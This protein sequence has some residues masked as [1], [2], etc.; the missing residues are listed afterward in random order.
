MCFVFS[1]CLISLAA[2]NDIIL[3]V[4][5]TGNKTSVQLD[6]AEYTADTGSIRVTNKVKIIT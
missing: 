5:A 1:N 3:D 2:Q 6:T 4:K